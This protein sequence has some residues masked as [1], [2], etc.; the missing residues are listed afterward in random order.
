MNDMMV[1]C[2]PVYDLVIVTHEHLN[3]G[4]LSGEYIEVISPSEV[5]NLI[6]DGKTKV[7]LGT[8]VAKQCGTTLEDIV[9]QGRVFV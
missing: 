2:A 3:E 1:T 6:A 5:E 7:D 9:T 4:Q 8:Q